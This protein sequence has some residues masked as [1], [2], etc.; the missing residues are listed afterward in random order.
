M[1]GVYAI[2]HTLTGRLYIGATRDL[3]RRRMAHYRRLRRGVHSNEILQAA[4]DADGEAAFDFRLL[5]EVSALDQLQERER[6]HLEIAK[7][8]GDV[9]NIL[10]VGALSVNLSAGNI[11]RHQWSDEKRAR[12]SA[13]LRGH[14]M[15]DA[16]KARIGAAHSGRPKSPVHRAKL[17]ANLDAVRPDNTGSKRTPETRERMKIAAR[18]GW[19]KRRHAVEAPV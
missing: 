14:Q 7:A 1:S 6:A 11:G 18:I 16:A 4:W 2:V 19:L 15:T 17:R 13:K 8:A 3:G 10:P 12:Q 9:F 5:E